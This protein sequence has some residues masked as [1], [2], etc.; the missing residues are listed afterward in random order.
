MSLQNFCIKVME[1]RRE[2]DSH[3][4]EIVLHICPGFGSNELILFPVAA[5]FWI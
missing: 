5:V 2:I 1:R 4:R 3:K